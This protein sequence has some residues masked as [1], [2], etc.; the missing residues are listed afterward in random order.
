MNDSAIH[1]I[2]PWTL[3]E[4]LGA[5]GNAV[6]WRAQDYRGV[7]A[8]VKVLK[9]QR[10]NSEPY[11]RFTR[12][13][14][15]MR[16]L[17]IEGFEGVLPLLA[18]SLPVQP[19]RH[20]PAWLAMPIAENVRAATAGATTS[21]VL[22]FIS[23]IAD[24][25]GKLHGQGV[26]H[27]DIKPENIYLHDGKPKLGDF[28]LVSLPDATPLTTGIKALGPRHYI[29]PEMISDPANADGAPADIYSLA[30]TLWVLLTSQRFPL[31][32]QHRADDAPMTVSA[33]LVDPRTA[34]IDLLIE[35]STA[36]SP[37][38]RPTAV[39]FKEELLAMNREPIPDD[40][41]PSIEDIG[42]RLNASFAAAQ[43]GPD[44]RARQTERATAALAKLAVAPGTVH[45]KLQSAGLDVSF[46]PVSNPT[47]VEAVI[48]KWEV[49]CSPYLVG[50]RRSLHRN[51]IAGPDENWPY[52]W[53]DVLVWSW[54][55]LTRQR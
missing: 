48:N 24:V 19:S 15:A 6:V 22:G 5:G 37:G 38:V 8:A 41:I 54:R 45:K 33:N 28:G 21:N 20:E 4:K 12:E 25:L 47:V 10:A 14:S 16:K 40:E 9:V 49:S 18:H 51:A 3:E 50:W 42:R 13:I 31:P 17:T 2:G 46:S 23:A 7:T 27:R 11:Q 30:K 52:T 26:T 53:S 43:R 1:Q 34:Q 35:R 44:T 32:G 36:T 29:A 39:Q 55:R